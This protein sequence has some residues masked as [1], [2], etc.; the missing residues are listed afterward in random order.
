[1]PQ[2]LWLL[3]ASDWFI[4]ESKYLKC[5]C[6]FDTLLRNHTKKIGTN[7]DRWT[8]NVK[9]KTTC[10]N[11]FLQG[12]IKRFQGQAVIKA[13]LGARIE[14]HLTTSSEVIVTIT[15]YTQ[16]SGI[17][18]VTKVPQQA[19]SAFAFKRRTSRA[20]IFPGLYVITHNE[21]ARRIQSSD[22]WWRQH[23]HLCDSVLGSDSLKTTTAG[24]WRVTDEVLSLTAFN[25][26]GNCH[27][28][29]D[30]G[31]T[32][33]MSHPH[34]GGIPLYTDATLILFHLYRYLWRQKT[35]Q[36]S[37]LDP[38]C[39]VCAFHTTAKQNESAT[40]PTSTGSV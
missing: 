6:Q 2:Q 35:E 8:N 34:H 22:A 26:F 17:R 11:Y 37:H 7:T 3:T 25:D 27:Q 38:L 15:A 14:R 29:Y 33:G 18:A 28:K 23:Q 30:R 16:R 19:V 32:E 13:I 4:F 39:R 24:D 21:P 12:G 31:E 40:K 20:G 10:H 1:M 9:T 5:L 36:Q